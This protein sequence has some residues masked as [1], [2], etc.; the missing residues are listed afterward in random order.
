MFDPILRLRVV[1]DLSECA[2]GELERQ[3]ERRRHQFPKTME[4]AHQDPSSVRARLS[5]EARPL[6][7]MLWGNQGW[8]VGMAGPAGHVPIDFGD[9]VHA[10]VYS[11]PPA[12]APAKHRQAEARYL[13][14]GAAAADRGSGKRWG[15][16]FS[17][18]QQTAP[19]FRD[20][21]VAVLCPCLPL[22]HCSGDELSA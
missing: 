15:G 8:V 12:C 21:Q 22:M 19:P 16:G 7:R 5:N 1:D 9:S 14:G 3:L 2:S 17:G 11:G 20:G 13:E 10:M 18:S 6:A 4:G